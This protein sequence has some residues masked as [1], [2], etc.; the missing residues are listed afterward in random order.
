MSTADTP[1]TIDGLRF[2]APDR[3]RDQLTG[4]KVLVLGLGNFGGGAGAAKALASWGAR[5][6]ITDLKPRGE[7]ESS[8][9]ALAD[10]E[11]EDW[12]LDGHDGVAL[13]DYD[14][15]LV[16]PAVPPSAPILLEA[17]RSSARLVTEIDLFL[18]WCPTSWVAG[19]TGSNGKTTTAKLVES[20]LQLS[21]ETVFLGGNFGGSLLEKI[22]EIS[23][24]DRVI[25]EL[26][27][28][29]LERLAATTP[30]PPAV[31]LTQFSANHIDWHRSLQRYRNAKLALFEGPVA[32]APEVAMIS[33]VPTSGLLS[34]SDLEGGERR[35]IPI[36]DRSSS[37]SKGDDGAFTFE[38]ASG[39]TVIR[40]RREGSLS[41]RGGRMNTFT[42]ATLASA[43]GASDGAIEEAI[44]RFPGLP[45][46][47][48]LI[49]EI[50]G[51]RYINDSKATTPEAAVVALEG[52]REKIHW[53][54]GGRPKGTSFT[55]L[56]EAATEKTVDVHLFGE[57]AETIAAAL[58]SCRFPKSRLHRHSDL[59]AAFDLACRLAR[60]GED[61]L[62]SPACASFDQFSDYCARGD[63]FREL[64]LAVGG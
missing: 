29:Q 39:T 56:A 18:N 43:L 30:R 62:L 20:M 41:G 16:N 51:V 1:T 13:A 33:V 60:P 36:S 26:S 50:D 14:W 21:G 32:N 35:L 4:L 57:G 6:S 19:I 44:G 46:R 42:A 5:V 3:N 61:I 59:S 48:E 22:P 45:H 37:A 40:D 10:S 7:L 15:V 55:H 63:L 11:I 47:R 23:G 24:E 31:A 27:S 53:L 54:V 64:A 17:A 2:E 38:A 9:E 52:C 49:V 25:I 12:H 58:E 28:F 8:I 34:F